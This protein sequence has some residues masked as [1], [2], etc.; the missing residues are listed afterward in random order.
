MFLISEWQKIS[1]A[2]LVV[3]LSWEVASIPFPTGVTQTECRGRYFWIWIDKT[4]LGQNT[5]T[6]S[7]FNELGQRIPV[8]EH[9]AAQCG[10]TR[11]TDLYGNPE[12]RVSFLGCSV[13]NL[14]DQDFSLR[15]QVEVTSPA[16]VTAAYDVSMKC[17]VDAPW[18]PREI[19]CEEN[20]MEVSVRRAVPG[21]ASEALNEDWVAVWPLAQG[22]VNQVW[23]VVFHFQNG[24]L[25]NMMATQAHAL[26]YG[27]NTTA[28]RV[29]FRTPYGTQQTEVTMV[30]GLEVEVARATVFYK[31]AWMILMV[32]TAVACPINSP[33]FTPTTLSWVTPR[34][35]PSL[36][37]FP[38]LF[39]DETIEMGLDGRL[40]DRATMA[41][42]G[43]TFLTDRTD[44]IS[45]TVPIGA[46]GG[47]TESDVMDNHYGTTY[48]IKLLLD[49]KWQGDESDR[50]RHRSLKAI[51]TLF[52]PQKPVLINNTIPEKGYFDVSLGN[53][54]P[55]V[56]LTTIGIGGMP[57]TPELLKPRGCH[58][59]E[60]ANPNKTRVLTLQVPFTDPLVEQKYLYGNI[61][62][63]TLH[64]DYTLNLVPK[65][66]PF[67]YPAVIECDVPDVV[68]PT[69][70]GF[71]DTGRIG[72]IMYRG[73]LDR[74]WLP[75]VGNMRVTS[76]LIVSQNYTVQDNANYYYLS[77]PFLAV[78]LA[79]QDISLQGL[80][81]R[82][83]FSLRDNKTLA[84]AVAF[85][86]A[87]I[88]PMGKLL[89]CLPNGTMTATVLSLDTKPSLDPRNTHLRDQNCGPVAADESR[90]LFSFPV[91]SCGTTRRF[92]GNYL[93][94]ENEVTFR[95]EMIPEASPVITRDSQYKLT[96]RCRY[97][98]NETLNVLAQ[99]LQGEMGTPVP[100][101]LGLRAYQ[102]KRSADHQ[103]VSQTGAAHVSA[104]AAEKI[105]LWLPAF[106][107]AFSWAAAMVGVFS[108]VRLH[109]C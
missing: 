40:I 105:W 36:V 62:R 76:E 52:A 3:L 98:L 102:Q 58:L 75:Y 90:A 43:Y 61:R 82:L 39:R 28:T 56:E 11:T 8:T 106:G 69:F 46:V 26:G 83:D 59:N 48:S 109:G 15:L 63:Y 22:A 21:V 6:Y 79:Y 70:E 47:V 51:R 54:L 101:V 32:D 5:W 108:P 37:G 93:V 74:Y 85:P 95:R 88:F 94:Y 67:I 41:R 80:T 78:G 17:R 65:A 30:H 34:I 68:L 2:L 73:N 72:L 10:F 38:H 35:M 23:Q 89:V 20:Y 7:V 49:R 16:N 27:V 57:L 50:T 87:C 71:C 97:P 18:S 100:Y 86:F 64:L 31:Q 66:K 33:V 92:E 84:T 91:T 42:N 1:L 99:R 14:F 107:M 81:A 45:I 104:G 19:V 77:V 103:N 44:F 96:L 9:V 25:Q 13:H 24:S 60:V 55:D 53:F 29:L 12:I 4:A